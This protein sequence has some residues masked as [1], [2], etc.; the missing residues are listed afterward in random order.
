MRANIPQIIYV[1][2]RNT[3]RTHRE[4]QGTDSSYPYTS[5]AISYILLQTK[6]EKSKAGNP[7]NNK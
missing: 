4:T 1:R 7:K 5:V 6:S 2:P 3:Q